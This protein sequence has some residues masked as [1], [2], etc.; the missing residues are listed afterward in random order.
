MV[1]TE[2]RYLVL[3]LAWSYSLAQL[4]RNS[5]SFFPAMTFLSLEASF[6]AHWISTLEFLNGSVSSLSHKR[7]LTSS[8]ETC[9]TLQW[10]ITVFSMYKCRGKWEIIKQCQQTNHFLNNVLFCFCS[11]DCNFGK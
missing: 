1:V 6:S 5:E 10:L 8:A 11:R 4:V 3:I 7:G 9:K 2:D